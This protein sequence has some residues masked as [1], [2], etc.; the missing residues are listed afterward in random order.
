MLIRLSS[1]IYTAWVTMPEVLKVCHHFFP[2][3]WYLKLNLH[4]DIGDQFQA[5]NKLPYMQWIFP[6][7]LENRDAMQRAW[8]T[9]TPLS[10]FPSQRPELD[11]P[12][13]EDGLKQSVEYIES[14]IDDL[15]DRDI[16]PNRIVIG[17]FSQGCAVTLLAGLMS[18]R[19]AGKVAGVAGLMGYLPLADKIQRLRSEAGL[20]ESVGDVPTFLARGKK[21][22]LVPRR[23]LT[24]AQQKLIELGLKD[25]ALEVHEYGGLGHTIHAPVIRDLCAWLEKIVPGLE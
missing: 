25:T 4:P 11:D 22:M 20:P 12:E 19:F 13:D 3:I 18:S 16:P 9:P 15:V 21:D 2:E 17:G 8:Y 24:I 10:P 23:Y 14:L 1:S 7:A 6:N 5:A